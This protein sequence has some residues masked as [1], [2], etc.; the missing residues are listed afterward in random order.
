LLSAAEIEKLVRADAYERQVIAESIAEQIIGRYHQ[1]L[2]EFYARTL[3]SFFTA[4]GVADD[5]FAP[6]LEGMTDS[7]NVILTQRPH[8]NPA[9]VWQPGDFV[10]DAGRGQAL[11]LKREEAKPMNAEETI[12]SCWNE[13]D[14]LRHVIVGRADGT[15][16]QAPEPAVVRDWP[17]DGFPRGTYGPLPGHMV[18]AANARLDDFADLLQCRGIRVDRPVPL[19]FDQPV[20]PPDW[21]QGSMFG[22]MPPR[23]VIITV[24][25]EL[26]ESTT[27]YRSRWFEY[28]CYRPL[29]QSYFTLDPQMHWEA[30]PKPR[31][32]DESYVQG[33]HDEFERLSFAEQIER[34]RRNEL[35]LTEFEP[36][37]DAADIVRFGRD[38]FVQLSL[39]TN[40]SGSRWLKQHFGDFRVHPITFDNSHPLHVDATWVPLRPGLVLHCGERLAQADLLEYFK[41]ND[42]EVIEAAPPNR[43]REHLPPL[44]FCSAWLSLNVLSLDPRTICVEATETAQMEQ[45]YKLGFE[46]IPV[47]FWDVAPFGG[48]LHCATVDIYREGA[49]QDY[50]PRRYGRF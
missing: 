5:I 10:I 6:L 24:G 25:R 35:G 33:F 19:G 8:V 27:C 47:P 37:F 39:V 2:M 46:V 34:V 50:F 11:R 26:L 44:C 41:I 29:I 18:E 48:G 9:A 32:T 7:P 14:P 49:C 1:H 31:L 38:L 42:W 16:V 22:C 12:V 28:L 45:L 15:M 36:L 21:T 4:M 23:D 17:E 40:R 43:D 3:R 20:A 13:W 30:A